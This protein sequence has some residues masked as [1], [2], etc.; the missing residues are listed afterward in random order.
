MRRADQEGQGLVEFAL[1]IIVFLVLVMG[2]VDFGRGIYTYNGVSQAAR[3]IARVASV[4]PGSPLG[5]DPLISPV[6][7]TQKNLVPALS[8]PTFICVDDTGADVSTLS[9]ARPCNYRTDSVKVVVTAPY[10]A[11]TPLLGLLGTWTMQGSS[12]A[13]IQ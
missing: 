8:G 6:V 11:I 9:P 5:T 13:Q 10:K 2:V 7:A 1:A 12:T 4:H 3:E